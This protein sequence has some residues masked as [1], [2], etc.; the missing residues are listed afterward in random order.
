MAKRDSI[1]NNL[2][3]NVKE[4]R[5]SANM[6]QADLADQAKIRQPLISKLEHGKG[7]PTLDSIVKVARALGVTVID[8]LDS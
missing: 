8:L 2:A 7:N 3:R 6:S 4:F 5:L 1:K